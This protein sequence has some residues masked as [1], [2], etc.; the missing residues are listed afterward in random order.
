VILSKIGFNFTCQSEEEAG[1]AGEQPASNK[2]DAITIEKGWLFQLFF[3]F[4]RVAAWLK[5]TH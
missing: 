1:N 2:V 4:Y 5:K 3:I